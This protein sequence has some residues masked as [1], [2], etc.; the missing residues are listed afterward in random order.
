MFYSNGLY[1]VFVSG[2][3]VPSIPQI[4]KDLDSTGPIVRYRE[5]N[6]CFKIFAQ[7]S[8]HSLAVSL[9]ILASSL[10]ALLGACYSSFCNNSDLFPV[11][12]QLTALNTRWQETDLP[13]WDTVPFRGLHW[14]R[15]LANHRAVTDMEIRPSSRS[16][17][18]FISGV[19]GHWRYL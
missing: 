12:I 17:S 8:V 4:A 1:S 7:W 5:N 14:R 13:C 18:W 9:S 16:F 15:R 2:T 19:R 10:G 11:Y 6:L 3:F